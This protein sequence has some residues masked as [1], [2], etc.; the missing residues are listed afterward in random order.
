VAA[1]PL[2]E[3]FESASH[4]T[5]ARVP[6]ENSFAPAVDREPNTYGIALRHGIRKRNHRSQGAAGI[7]DFRL[8]EIK[9][10]FPFDVPRA[11]VVADGVTDDLQLGREDERQFRLR[12]APLRILA[13]SYPRAGTHHAMG[14]AFEE[15][16]GP[17][18]AIDHVVELRRPFG[19]GLSRL[20]T[21]LV[22]H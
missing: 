8:R 19:L 18:G 2:D 1:E 17:R 7:V 5:G 14:R 22:R 20:F 4:L 11:H 16:L 3:V 9:R 13:N 21:A 12:D 6:F 10:V 15:E